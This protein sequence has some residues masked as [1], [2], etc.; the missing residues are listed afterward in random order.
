M[1]RAPRGPTSRGRCLLADPWVV[2]AR[3][4]ARQQ[5]GQ[6]GEHDPDAHQRNEHPA[7]AHASQERHRDDDESDQADRDRDTGRE[8]GMAG[9][10]HRDD[11][12]L[13]VVTP[14]RALLTPSR[15]QKQGVVDRHPQPDQGDQ[16]LDDEADVAER[17][18][19]Q[20]QDERGQDRHGGD[21]K[22]QQREERREDEHQ[23]Q[24]RAGGTQ[25]RLGENARPLGV[26]SCGKQSV[27]RQPAL[28]TLPAGGLGERWF[29]LDLDT[30][31]ER[32]R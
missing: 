2:D 28:E 25:Q 32:I 26:A 11:H 16:E 15:H 3:A 4:D 6:Q 18:Q 1:A 23:H 27:R 24:Q 29:D 10:L 14:V 7:N 5:G 21:Q 31:A 9:R 13:L 12:S 22:R 8:H 20:H 30:R 17:G 19:P